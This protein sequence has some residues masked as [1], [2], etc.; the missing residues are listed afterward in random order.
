MQTLFYKSLEMQEKAKT[1]VE[2][3]AKIMKLIAIF[4]FD[5]K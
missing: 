2:S 4:I 5:S 1:E 3:E